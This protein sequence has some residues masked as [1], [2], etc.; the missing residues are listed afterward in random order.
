MVNYDLPW[1][2]NR[3]EQRF[4]RIHRIGQTEVCHLWNLV[5]ANT[6]EGEVFQRLL[7]KMEEQ[8]AAYSG[9]VFDILG[10]SFDDQPLRE[11]LIK[12][13]RYGDQPEVRAQLDVVIDAT[14][15]EGAERLIAERALYRDVLAES[16]VEAMRRR[17]EDAQAR[18]LQPHYIQAFFLTAFSRLGGRIVRREGGRY[19]IT[20]VPQAI[21]DRDRMIGE[22]AP[23]LTGYERVCFER[24]QRRVVGRPIAELVAPG[25]PLLGAVVDL[26][27]EQ[28][29]RALKEGA[30]LLDAADAGTTPRL[31]VAM[32]QSISDGHVPPRTISKRFDFVELAPDGEAV[33]AGPAPY[34][35]YQPIDDATAALVDPL[36]DQEWLGRGVEDIAVG[37]AVEHSLAEHTREI[38]ARVVPSVER[39]RLE[40]RR[41]LLSEINF[42]DGQHASLLDKEAAG[43][44]L[45]LRPETAAKRARD[46][47]A[48]L[49]RRLAALDADAHL[50]THP[51][52]IAGAALV[53][54][55]GLVD[56]LLGRSSRP[57]EHARDTAAVERRAVDA[58]LA[59]ERALGRSPH[60]MDHYNPGYDIRSEANGGPPIRIEVK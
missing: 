3:L 14:V 50:T 47:E 58:V 13:I 5:A 17:L 53:I 45:R 38:T 24:D 33:P 28:H 9:K 30:I 31:L 7:E 43:Q 19:E 22:G 39:T 42:W 51:P 54:P 15:S 44:K 25:H 1:N 2:P 32:N 59:S 46:L 36:L 23:I 27:V 12:A 11:L 8:R 40:V 60:E 57:P 49:E 34:L 52:L 55:Q 10:D 48:R 20:H 37:W 4:G 29:A 41:R 16:D 6:R 56:E 21:R 26:T 35:D 18:R